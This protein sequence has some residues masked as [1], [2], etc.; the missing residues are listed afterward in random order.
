[1]QI[2]IG[3]F[4]TAKECP[5]R[6]MDVTYGRTRGIYQVLGFITRAK[7]FSFKRLYLENGSRYGQGYY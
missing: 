1:M 5:N 4:M 2:L 3:S 7:I 6:R